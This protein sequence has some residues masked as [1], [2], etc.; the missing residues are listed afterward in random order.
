M[1]GRSRLPRRQRAAAAARL[2]AGRAR[3]AGR[4][5]AAAAASRPRCGAA[6]AAPAAR[7]GIPAPA[8]DE[9][10][11]SP[12]PLCCRRPRAARR[13]RSSAPRRP[14]TAADDPRPRWSCWPR[15]LGL[16]RSSA[17]CCC[18]ASALELDP[19]IAGALRAR[20]TATRAAVA[21]LRAGAGAVRRAGVG[22]A[23]AGAAAALLAADRG[24][25][26]RRDQPLTDERAAG[27]R[28]DRRLRQGPQLPRRAARAARC[29]RRAGR[30]TRRCRA[31]QQAAVGDGR[32]LAPERRPAPAPP[33]VSA[34]RHATRQQAAGRRRMSPPRS[35]CTLYRLPADAA[36]G[37]RRAELETL[38]PAVASARCLLLPL[39]L[40]VDAA[41]SSGRTGR[42][43][44]PR[45]RA[46]WRAP[47][48]LVFVDARDAW[49]LASAAARCRGESTRPT[50]RRA[51]RGLA[52][53]ARRGGPPSCR[54]GWPASSTSTSPHIARSPPPRLAARRPARPSAAA[55]GGRLPAH[56]A[57]AGRAGR[58]ASTPQADAG[59]TSCCRRRSCACCARSRPRSRHRA[60]GLRRLGLR[61]AD[62]P[63][64]GHQRAVRRRERHRQ[65]A[66]PPRS[67]PT[68][69]RL[70]LYRIDLSAVVSKYIGE[71][72]KNLRRVF[73]AAEDGGAILFFDEADA[74]F[75]KRSEVQGQPRPLRQ[76]R[77][78]LPAAAHGGAIAGLA[79]L[80]TNMKSALDPAFMRRLRF[81]VNFPFPGAAERRAIW[82]AAFPPETPTEGARLRPLARLD[83]HRRQHPQH[84]AERRLP[85]R[86]SAA[87]GVTMPLV[88]ERRAH[89]A[90]QARPHR[91]RRRAA[92]GRKPPTRPA[93][94]IF[95]LHIERPALDGTPF[96][97]GDP[98]HF[99]ASLE[100]RLQALLTRARPRWARCRPSISRRCPVRRLL[101]SCT[102]GAAGAG[103][104]RRRLARAGPRHAM[105][106]ATPAAPTGMPRERPCAARR[107]ARDRSRCA[108]RSRRRACSSAVAPA[109]TAP[110]AARRATRAARS[111]PRPRS[112]RRRRS[113]ALDRACL[114]HALASTCR[115]YRH[116]ASAGSPMKGSSRSSWSPRPATRTSR[117]PTG[118]PTASCATRP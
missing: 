116:D 24:R 71:T 36:A 101:W 93:L 98:A 4:E 87:A 5:R 83:L 115:A 13:G 18:C 81:V 97:G 61:G 15:R 17:T 51:A 58:S 104:V 19:R 37:R 49:P 76:H 110:S 29:C 72:E 3:A 69:S 79:I 50:R 54:R 99:R 100:A 56:A 74:L 102:R 75:G 21:D 57:A 85:G 90:A 45:G 92:L 38:A 63:R 53:S 11:R 62:E 107:A 25:T 108:L 118:S 30:T 117:K 32:G 33:G 70:D 35:A 66:W 114:M 55:L 89:R 39:A 84:R 106:A 88:L 40:I 23:V 48:A 96:E 86:R 44:A 77:D 7:G 80:A 1:A 31:S 41:R 9:R 46:S 103:L 8:G 60:H 27:R 112:A 52:A 14:R 2:S 113:P 94:R 68:S 59:T 65:D 6:V 109:A 26:S 67:S 105:T 12:T 64:P 28:A 16:P 43:A 42:A 95:Y 73:D 78:Q 20:R 82:A 22:G 111:R 91:Q 10:R 34:D 47:A